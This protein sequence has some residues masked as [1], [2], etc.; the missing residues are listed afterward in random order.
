MAESSGATIAGVQED[1]VGHTSEIVFNQ[2]CGL[3]YE[4]WCAMPP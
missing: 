1:K 4:G 2:P 3:S